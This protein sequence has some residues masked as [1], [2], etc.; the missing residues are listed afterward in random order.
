MKNVRHCFFCLLIAFLLCGSLWAEEKNVRKPN[1]AGQF[2]PGTRGA[3]ESAVSGYLEQ[4][5]KEELSGQLRALVAPHA[6]YMYSGPIAAYAYEQIDRPFRRVVILASNHSR[7]ANFEGISVPEFT[8]YATPLG[9]VRVSPLAQEWLKL[10]RI[11]YD[12]AA[13]TTHII[14][15]HL[16]FLQTVL[17]E[18]F[19]ILPMITGRID[20]RDV[21]RFGELLNTLVDEDTLFIVS[22]DLSHYHGYEE[23]VTLDTTCIQAIEQLDT[24]G[25]IQAELCGQGAALILMEVAKKQ[26]W[27]G[28]ILDY[29][30]SGDTAGDKNR[31]V[32]Y[33]AIAFSLSGNSPV[34]TGS[35]SP[36]IKL[37]EEEQHVL[38]ELA[39]ETVELYVKEGNAFEPERDQFA[40]YPRLMEERGS[41][42]TLKK[43]GQLRGCIGNIIGRQPLYLSIRDNAIRAA[44]RDPRF[45]PVTEADLTDITVSVSVL[46]VPRPFQV[47][48]PDD[49]LEQLT[50]QDGVILISGNRSATYLPQVWK[51]LPKPG[52]FLSRL[53]L[54]AG[55]SANCW[56][57]PQTQVYT[58]RA[59][60]FGEE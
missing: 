30:N 4:A 26:G 54:K 32:G 22:T 49:Y 25:V 39:Q 59:Q 34:Q 24:S 6:G 2:Y 7:V 36:V 60:E 44:T 31:V 3:L 16:P 21:E 48:S 20:W 23:A 41:F 8:H 29:R 57:N 27:Q 47:D 55:T 37:S 5:V 14:E 19:E 42:V 28:K 38:V 17:P 35:D 11:T 15:V 45:K 51:E 10:D 9:E 46:D 58:Y 53:C 13:H 56:R 43:D 12:D 18:N 40:A 52:E 50:H 1:V 33:A